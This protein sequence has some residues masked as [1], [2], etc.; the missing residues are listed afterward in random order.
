MKASLDHLHKTGN[1]KPLAVVL[2]IDGGKFGEEAKVVEVNS[3]VNSDEVFKLGEVF[4][5]K[6]SLLHYKADVLAGEDSHKELTDNKTNMMDVPRFFEH[7]S[8]NH[9]IDDPKKIQ[10][11]EK[12]YCE[13]CNKTLLI[14]DLE[15][16]M[17][18]MHTVKEKR[19][20]KRRQLVNCNVC[21][22][23]VRDGWNLTRHMRSM[24]SARGEIS[25]PKDFCDSTFE[26][27]YDMKVKNT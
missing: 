13:Q 5:D 1:S 27:E 17:K 18:K 9:M 16:H 21:D 7:N 4:E 19:S 22:Q 12:F 20:E 6:S 10:Q 14:F 23:T 26:S 25:C 11:R 3:H 2:G 8:E 24:H 15:K